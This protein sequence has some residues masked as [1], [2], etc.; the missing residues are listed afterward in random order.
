MTTTPAPLAWY[1]PGFDHEAARQKALGVLVEIS[2]AIGNTRITS[3]SISTSYEVIAQF[4]GA[5]ADVATRLADEWA[6]GAPQVHVT[7]GNQH[8]NWVFALDG[9]AVRI[10]T[11]IGTR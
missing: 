4:S 7:K 9:V 1:D 2:E 8:T 10:I 5:E 11:V 6:A 3:L